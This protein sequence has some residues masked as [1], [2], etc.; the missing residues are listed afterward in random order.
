[1]ESHWD[2]MCACIRYVRATPTRGLV[3][4]PTGSWNDKDENFMFKI[5]GRSNSNFTTDPES[6][7]RVTG[8]IVYLNDVPIEFSSVT[9]KHVAL[10]VT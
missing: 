8:I 10:S 1:M 2:S 9:Q 5:R 6:R 4:K 7:T 3:L